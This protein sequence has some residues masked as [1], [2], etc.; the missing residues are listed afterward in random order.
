MRI[1][2]IDPGQSGG[3]ACLCEACTWAEPMPTAG[4]EVDAAALAALVEGADVCWI[5][6]VHSMPRQGVA[7]TFKFGMNYGTVL[8]VCG[9]LH[10]PVQLVTPQKWKAAVLADTLKDKAAAIAY[11]RR[12]WPD[13]DLRE[14]ER[15]RVAHDGKADALCIAAYGGMQR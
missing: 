15:C 9:A 5:E 6:K 10:V 8:G 3:I 1:I 12:R 2:G 14:N 7:T 4:K 13:L 11:C